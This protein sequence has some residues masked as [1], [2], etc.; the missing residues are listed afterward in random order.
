MEAQF[1]RG[2]FGLQRPVSV[3]VPGAVKAENFPQTFPGQSWEFKNYR[4]Q[5]LPPG[6][7]V[8]LVG[9]IY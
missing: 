1:Q 2:L 9:L 4:P 5:L 6:Q 8:S 3:E 7:Q